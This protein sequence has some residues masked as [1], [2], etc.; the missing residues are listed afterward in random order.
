MVDDDGASSGV[1]KTVEVGSCPPRGDIQVM[2]GSVVSTLEVVRFSAANSTD[3]DGVVDTYR[4]SFGDGA[5]AFGI[6]VEHSH[7]DP[8]PVER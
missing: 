3:P 6:D 8:G 7:L 5:I 1:N 2:G 4:W